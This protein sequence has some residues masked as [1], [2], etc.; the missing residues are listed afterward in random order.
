M[1]DKKDRYLLD[2]SRIINIDENRLDV[3]E[4]NRLLL[5]LDFYDDNFVILELNDSLFLQ[6][7]GNLE[8]GFYL[9]YGENSNIYKSVSNSV[10][11]KTAVEICNLFIKQ[12][13]RWKNSIN[14]EP[15]SVE[16][17]NSQSFYIKIEKTAFILFIILFIFLFISENYI[18]FDFLNNYQKLLS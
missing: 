15:I 2:D 5:S 13:K 17:K 4:L 10:S 1:I 18:K 7:T 16:R 8:K 3:A 6:I 11:L 9:E 12:D 14:W